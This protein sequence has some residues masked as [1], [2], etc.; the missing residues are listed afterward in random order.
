VSV[1]DIAARR[2]AAH[3][4]IDIL[5]GYLSPSADA[6]VS[7]RLRQ[8]AITCPHRHAMCRLAP[9]EH[10]RVDAAFRVI[11][12]PWEGLQFPQFVADG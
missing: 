4:D 11:A 8:E 9:E 3:H 1:F 2:L 10:N 6:W 5:A 7:H 12:D